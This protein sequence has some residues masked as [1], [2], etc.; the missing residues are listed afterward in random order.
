MEEKKE[1]KTEVQKEKEIAT[2]LPVKPENKIIDFNS[3]D[4]IVALPGK[5]TSNSHLN[6]L[7]TAHNG[8]LTFAV[9]YGALLSVIFYSLIFFILVKTF[10]DKDKNQFSKIVLIAFLL[11]NL[12]NDL[13]Y[14]PDAS[15][16]LF[17][18]ISYLVSGYYSSISRFSFAKS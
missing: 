8:Y 6:Q 11:Q 2:V 10:S 16:F 13:I 9:E 12:T 14:S 17:F 7:T 1:E 5:I 15:L 3:I 18:C 4:K